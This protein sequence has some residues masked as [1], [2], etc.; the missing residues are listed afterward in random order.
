MANHTHTWQCDG[1]G[2]TTTVFV[3]ANAIVHATCPRREARKALPVYRE[4][5]K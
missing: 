1:C 5:T 4:V 2:A 3:K